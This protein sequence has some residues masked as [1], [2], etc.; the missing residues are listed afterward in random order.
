MNSKLFKKTFD[1]ENS[2]I[3]GGTADATSRECRETTN[4][5][6]DCDGVGDTT[7]SYYDDNGVLETSVTICD[8][9]Q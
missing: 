7:Y 4:E 9:Q 1:L 2:C 8:A 5:S 6:Y 3:V